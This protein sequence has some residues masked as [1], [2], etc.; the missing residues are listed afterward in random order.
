MELY[1]D[2]EEMD[3]VII[4]NDRERHWRMAFKDND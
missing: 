3:D 4:N 2:E 1:P